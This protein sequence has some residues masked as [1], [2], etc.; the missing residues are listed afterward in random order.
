LW[1][2]P[3]RSTLDAIREAT[4]EGEECLKILIADD[5]EVIR[6]Q[7]RFLLSEIEGA[8]V[9]TAVDG[10]E[11]TWLIGQFAPQVV[12]LDIQ[13]PHKNGIEVLR[14]IRRN[15]QSC[16]VIMFTAAPS[17]ETREICFRAG[18]NFF[19]DKRSEADTLL[20]IC[21]REA[22]LRRDGE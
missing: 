22:L 1:P 17:P 11:A 16:T 3:Q 10:M 9:E 12:I 20:E 18:A 13:M 21:K 19:L 5:T 4:L 7:L 6:K 8:V 14:E 2:P 15:D